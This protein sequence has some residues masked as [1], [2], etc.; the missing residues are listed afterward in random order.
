MATDGVKIIDG[1]FAHDLYH[2]FMDLYDSGIPV[3]A[4]KEKIRSHYES[5]PLDAFDEEI[6]VTVLAQA[7]WE[8][9]EL[10]DEILGRVKE[11]IEEERGLREWEQEGEDWY[12]K[13]KRVLH[14]FL[15]KIQSPRVR[16]R[17]RKR[18]RNIGNLVFQEGECLMLPLPDGRTAGF[19]VCE[20]SQKRGRCTYLLAFV[21]LPNSPPYRLDSF[22]S[23]SFA[24]H[25]YPSAGLSNLENLKFG[26]AT[27][28]LEH[29]SFKQLANTLSSVGCL[30]LNRESYMAVSFY[31][32][33]S[34]DDLIES[35]TSTVDNLQLWNKTLLSMT[36]IIG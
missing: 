3:S 27:A 22:R 32:V 11:V 5:H 7:L 26:V 2:E 34:L 28:M 8:I 9:G 21:V 16:I 30:P 10:D 31:P 36:G 19:V 15:Q 20:I 1:D 14:R 13:R 29:R 33:L 25:T 6:Y 12:R 23:A 24:G 18:H 4:I 35:Y 17:R